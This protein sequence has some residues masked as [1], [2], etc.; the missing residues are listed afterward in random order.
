MKEILVAKDLVRIYGDKSKT[1]ALDGV[2]LTVSE[3]DFICIMGPS[4]SGKS[5]FL[6][7]IATIDMPNTGVVEANGKSV[8]KMTEHG[9]SKFRY[10]NIGFIFQ[11]FNLID[12]LSIR[13]NIGVPLMLSGKSAEEINAK[14]EDIAKK[15]NISETLDKFPV[16]CSG[17]QKQRAASARALVGNP[18]LIV[19]DEPTGSLDTKSSHELLEILKERNEK[20]GV[21]ILMVTHDSMVASY[22]KKLVFLRDGK[23]DEAIEREELSQKEFFYKIV[24]ITSRDSQSLFNMV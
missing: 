13:E 4:G 17:G 19:A 7:T 23:I 1:R 5:T 10:E 14:V 2:S 9:L 15:L 24:D 12:S 22:S 21:A 11:E 16:E 8:Y 20:D 18:K 6:N 3:G